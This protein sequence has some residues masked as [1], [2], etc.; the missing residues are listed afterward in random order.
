MMSVSHM[1]CFGTFFEI[2]RGGAETKRFVGKAVFEVLGAGRDKYQT[3]LACE[4]NPKKQKWIEHIVHP[5]SD[6]PCCLHGDVEKLTLK[7][8]CLVHN[9]ACSIVC[10]RHL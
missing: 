1:R 2:A 3:K 5:I 7:P 6:N 8:I 4:S 10:P 9:E